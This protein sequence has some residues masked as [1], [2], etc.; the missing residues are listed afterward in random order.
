MNLSTPASSL[1][2]PP[3]PSPK[4]FALILAIKF[5]QQIK[6]RSQQI[7]HL[8]ITR[9]AHAIQSQQGGKVDSSLH[10]PAVVLLPT[11]YQTATID[12]PVMF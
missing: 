4:A 7:T 1:N 8:M 11:H 12:L 9:G 3:R 2:L 5:I 6:C 10:S